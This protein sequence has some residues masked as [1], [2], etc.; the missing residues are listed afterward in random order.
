MRAPAES[1]SLDAGADRRVEFT[2]IGFEVIGDALFGCEP[3][4]GDVIEMQAGE[5]VMPG[6][7]VGDQRIPALGP[8]AFSDAGALKDKVGDA[9][10]GQMLAGGNAGL[11]CADDQRINLFDR[12]PAAL[13]RW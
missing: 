7:A 3:I 1:S 2:G 12:H 11:T 8:P 6:G 13:S 4:G 5:A 9:V 10:A